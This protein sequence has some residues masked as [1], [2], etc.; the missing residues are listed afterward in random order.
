MIGIK[1]ANKITKK[2]PQNTSETV[3][4]KTEILK[5]RYI[6]PEERKK[7]IDELGLIGLY[8]NII[9]ENQKMINLLGNAQNQPSKFRKINRIEIDDDIWETF[10]TNSQITFKTL[11]LKSSLCDYSDAY[12]LLSRTITI[13]GEKDY[14]AARQAD[15]RNK[16][17]IFKNYAPFTNCISKINNTQVDNEKFNFNECSDNYSEMSRSLWKYHRD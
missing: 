9:M 4:T 13:T 12:I 16:E 14:T 1:Y 6:S 8:N 11:M 15:E 2:L 3:E 7:N 10:N 5:G 17:I